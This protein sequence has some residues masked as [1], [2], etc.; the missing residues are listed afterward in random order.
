MRLNQP[1]RKAIP[2][3]HVCSWVANGLALLLLT[4]LI[5]M[6]ICRGTPL[7]PP[8]TLCMVYTAGTVLAGYL[9]LPLPLAEQELAGWSALTA[10]DAWLLLVLH[11]SVHA[12]V[13]SALAAG[14]VV[15]LLG[16]LALFCTA[17]L[18]NPASARLAVLIL[19]SLT[20]AA[21]LWL[22][23][24]AER[25]ADT[26]GIVNAVIA[27]SPL[28]YLAVMAGDDYL[29]NAWFY[30]HTSLGSLRYAYPTAAGF[31]VVYLL[32]AG[33]SLWSRYP[34]LRQRRLESAPATRLPSLPA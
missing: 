20:T 13:V 31:S 28:S 3:G 21:P 33:I 10:L 24:L 16:S 22:G 17:L 25:F 29:H 32:L 8:G 4:Q 7:I 26:P 15:F 12:S 2:S 1:L 19:T 27:V 6:S 9:L 18:D 11:S 23:P 34:L 30:Q 5:G 14:V